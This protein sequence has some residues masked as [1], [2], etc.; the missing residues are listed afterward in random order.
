MSKSSLLLLFFIFIPL[1]SAIYAQ[2]VFGLWQTVDDRTGQPKALVRIYEAGGKMYGK[3]EKI[4]VKEKVDAQC[5]DCK[6][7]RKNK[8]LLGLHIIE[9]LEKNRAGHWKGNTLFDPEQNMIFR[10]KIWQE[11]DNPD[12]LKVRGYLAFLYRTQTWKRVRK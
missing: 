3:I 12:E 2:G 7:D 6:G 10:C 11:P 4:L 9:G 1:Y 8:P 5:I